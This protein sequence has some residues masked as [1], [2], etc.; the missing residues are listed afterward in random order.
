MFIAISAILACI[1]LIL[2]LY[3]LYL[4]KKSAFRIKK[5]IEERKEKIRKD[6]LERSRA[7][8]KGQL[9]E[10]LAPFSGEFEF[11]A[12]DARFLG[13]PVDYIIFDGVSKGEDEIK[14]IISD[15]K[16]GEN[17]KLT[18]QQKK[19]KKAVDNNKVEWK[20]IRLG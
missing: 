4:R 12:S 19:I 17:A 13:S 2:I 16:T 9:S 11:N 14:V 3:V 1:V 8:L 5:E 7:S 6:V 15:V 10:Q 18:P 20:T